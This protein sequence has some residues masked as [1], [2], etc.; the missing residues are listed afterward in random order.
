MSSHYHPSYESPWDFPPPPLPLDLNLQPFFNVWTFVIDFYRKLI[1]L[2]VFFKLNFLFNVLI[3]L[4]KK[5]ISTPPME[6]LM[7]I[8]L[9][10]LFHQYNMWIFL[11]ELQRVPKF[12][13]YKLR[14]SPTKSGCWWFYQVSVEKMWYITDELSVKILSI[15]FTGRYTDTNWLSHIFIIIILYRPNYWWLNQRLNYRPMKN[16]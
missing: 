13:L 6:T 14:T 4:K 11:S 8:K 12:F 16:H 7:R 5:Q 1:I 10:K 15:I 3:T 2:N 9:H